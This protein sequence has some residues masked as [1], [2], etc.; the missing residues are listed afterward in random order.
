MLGVYV[1]SAV[2]GPASASPFTIRFVF[3]ETLAS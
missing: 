3:S 1:A 2:P